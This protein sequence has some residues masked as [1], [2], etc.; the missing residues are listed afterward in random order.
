MLCYVTCFVNMI[1]A[2]VLHRSMHLEHIKFAYCTT[3][4]FID[5]TRV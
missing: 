4:V 2:G 1:W 3:L 5:V